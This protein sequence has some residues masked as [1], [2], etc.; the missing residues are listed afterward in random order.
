LKA[1]FEAMA[2]DLGRSV[3]DMRGEKFE[4]KNAEGAGDDAAAP[5]APFGDGGLGGN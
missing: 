5:D 1:A 3:A 2:N 4:E